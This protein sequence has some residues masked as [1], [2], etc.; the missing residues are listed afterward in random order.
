[1]VF[2]RNHLAMFIYHYSDIRWTRLRM[3]VRKKKCV[4]TTWYFVFFLAL[5]CLQ[6]RNDYYNSF[7]HE[8]KKKTNE[9]SSKHTHLPMQWHIHRKLLFVLT[10]S[11]PEKHDVFDARKFFS[12]FLFF[13][14]PFWFGIDTQKFNLIIFPLRDYQKAK[15]VPSDVALI[16]QTKKKTHCDEETDNNFFF[17]IWK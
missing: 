6:N 16:K 7:D 13:I 10:E 11:T 9:F 14:L 2:N 12:S 17:S 4:C 3:N 1:M 5:I 15:G 8:K